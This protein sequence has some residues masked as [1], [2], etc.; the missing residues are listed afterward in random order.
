MYVCK[1]VC[2]KKNDDDRVMVLK[3]G[4]KNERFIME[5]TW[6]AGSKVLASHHKLGVIP[7]RALIVDT[8]SS[9]RDNGQQ[10]RA[11]DLSKKGIEKRGNGT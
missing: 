8:S 6:E 10:Q 7:A 1:C 3:K 4:Y 2:A 11:R 9:M 5:G